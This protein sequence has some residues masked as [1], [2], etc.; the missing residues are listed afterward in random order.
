[1]TKHVHQHYFSARHGTIHEA[2]SAAQAVFGLSFASSHQH[3]QLTQWDISNTFERVKMLLKRHLK[4]CYFLD[5]FPRCKLST[6]Q[7]TMSRAT[8]IVA[9]PSLIHSFCVLSCEHE[10]NY[11]W[12]PID[13]Q[14]L[15]PPV[16]ATHHHT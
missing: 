9:P 15:H 6:V 2:E 11:N 10:D 3:H 12:P 7:S 14:T 8:V 4:A 16:L 5:D 13:T 1:M